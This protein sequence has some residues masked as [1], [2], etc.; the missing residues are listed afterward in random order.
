MEIKLIIKII[1]EVKNKTSMNNLD[2]M[3]NET[4]EVKL[5][6]FL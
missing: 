5:K 6:W 2:S 3:L 1:S 4:S